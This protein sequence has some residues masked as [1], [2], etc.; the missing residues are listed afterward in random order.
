MNWFLREAYD[1]ARVAVAIAS[2]L[3]N[4]AYWHLRRALNGKGPDMPEPACPG[5]DC[6]MCS[7]EACDLCG[8][9]CWSNAVT[10]GSPCE[11]DVLERHNG[12]PPNRCYDGDEHEGR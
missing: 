4:A 5:P 8:A 10:R 12:L 11:H 6:M 7:G 9:G 1:S 3:A 2:M